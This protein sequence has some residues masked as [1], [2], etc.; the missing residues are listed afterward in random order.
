MKTKLS[1]TVSAILSFFLCVVMLCGTVLPAIA[2]EVELPSL[3]YHNPSLESTATLS[4]YELYTALLGEPSTEGE[5]LYWQTSDL[6]LTYTKFIPDSC[7]DTRYDG[8]RGVLDITLYSYSYLAAN[9]TEI[10]WIPSVLFL[11]GQAYAVTANGSYYTS[12]IENCFHSG[13]FDMQVDYVCQIEIPREVVSVLRHEA[14]QEGYDAL[15]LMNEYRK[16]LNVY[17]AL[18]EM[19]NKWDAYEKW[20]EDYAN[21]LIEKA[22]YDQLKQEYDAYVVEYNAYQSLVDAYN[23]W[24]TYFEEQENFPAKQQAYAEY[25]NYYREYKAA[26]DKL[27]MFE[28][29]FAKDSHGWCMYNDIMGNAVTEVLSKQDLLVTSGC[30]PD[31]IYLAGRATENLR[32]LLKGY[33][34]LRNKKWSSDH[35]KY[36]ALYTY[37]TQNYDALKQNFCDLYKTLKGLYENT[38][39]SNFI[40][41]KGKTAH[42]RQLVGHLF[43]ISTSLD[44]S[45]ERNEAAWRIDKLPLSSVIEDVHYF[46]DGDW[47]PKNTS[48]PKV[49]VPFAERAE[50]P[51]EPSVDLPT[52]IPD[53]PQE[54]KNPGEPPA[55]VEDPSGT[56]RPDAPK[57]IGDKP[58]KPVFNAAVELLYQEV[59]NGQLKPFEEY[60]YS[61]TLTLTNT[62]DRKISIQNLK[63]VTFYNPD[64]TVFKQLFVDY[65]GT[66]N[67]SDLKDFPFDE[68]PAHTYEWF[69][70]LVLLPNGGSISVKDTM[71][72]TENLSLYPDYVATA[73]TY[74]ITWVVDGVATT[75]PY[76]YGVTPD[77]RNFISQ[78]PYETQSHRY[79]FS[80]W[81]TEILPVTSD[82]TYEGS[83]VCIPK[84]FSITWVI[85]NGSESIVEQWEYGQTP[86]FGG[87]LSYRDAYYTYSFVEWD[88]TVSPVTRAIT[89]TAV[90]KKEALALGGLNVPMEIVES[91]TDILVLATES[92]LQ[93]KQAALLADQSGKTL[94]VE[95]AGKL[96]LSMSGQELKN[97][98][99]CG[100]PTLSFYTKQDG[101]AEVYQLEFL[102]N[103]G[104]TSSLPHV[105]VQFVHHREQGRETVFEVETENGWVRLDDATHTTNGMLVARCRYAYSIIPE[106]NKLCNVTQMSSKALPGDW[107]SLNLNCVFGYKVVGAKVTDADGNEISLVGLSFQMPASAVNVVLEVERIVYRVTFMVNGE[108]WHYAEY[109][110]G[111]EILLPENPPKR[112]EGEYTYT[113]TGW[114][115]VPAIVMG[116]VE[117]LVFEA[118]FAQSTIVDD[119]DTG[120]NNNVVMTIVL[121]IAGA[122]LILLIAFLIT[123][124]IVRKKGGWRL[125]K[126]KFSGKMRAL[127]KKLKNAMQAIIKKIK[128]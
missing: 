49:E 51:V 32:V 45:S 105:T 11:E 110:A 27:A 42:Y 4:A 109:F 71:N 69:G 86:S 10:T 108:V 52:F 63:T 60:V 29:I 18:V 79:E 114:G 50:T 97:F 94:T 127:F 100:A 19:Q 22:L 58:Q 40:G 56:P 61:E 68:T 70:W 111:D 31:D 8:D 65:D 89:Y 95:W 107:V 14:Y 93:L 84:K 64:G 62:V 54:V 121:P 37:Y 72:V 91:D 103:A 5:K 101:D 59:E 106:A 16:K 90:Y 120:N 87:N 81:N 34:D 124:R 119:Y 96:T 13:D 117:E 92:A 116:D 67:A 76:Y 126:I 112:V 98:I 30:N 1:Y 88:K 122:V 26:V 85:K 48:Y 21:Y 66:I 113:F 38:V 83:T 53:P 35:D 99:A 73:K 77:P 36:Q 43:V 104:N 74:N 28:A 128:K 41:V 39:V 17:E 47:D 9:G 118:S 123:N 12:H 80:G 57:P 102:L 82:A 46:A 115:S 2:E 25:M 75:V 44:Q 33:A 24:Q 3:D 15:T 125:A 20:E 7:I 6:A 23:A 55:V 78:F